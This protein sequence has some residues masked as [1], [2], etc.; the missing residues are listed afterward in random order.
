MEPN[1]V[2]AGKSGKFNG[3]FGWPKLK[4]GWAH[5][6]VKYNTETNFSIIF[7]A[8]PVS[9]F[10]GRGVCAFRMNSRMDFQ[11]YVQTS[12]PFGGLMWV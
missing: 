9:W 2:G 10:L 8:R 7:R 11:N 6:G 1:R 3:Q 12:V 4:L 5:M